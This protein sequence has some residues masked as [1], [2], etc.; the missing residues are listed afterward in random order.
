MR[1]ISPT[2]N[3]FGRQRAGVSAII[4]IQLFVVAMLF[5]FLA[6]NRAQIQRHYVSSQVSSDLAARWGVDLLSRTGDQDL[7]QTQCEELA[8]LNWAVSANS[9]TVQERKDNVGVVV[10]IG[11]AIPTSS[12][13]RFVANQAPFNAVR[14]NN[15]AIV[16]AA[17]FRS[18]EQN[19][20][21][22]ERDATAMAIQRDI[23]VVIDRSGS[24]NFDKTGGNWI[25]D[26]SYHPYNAISN[27]RSRYYRNRYAWFWYW[28]HPTRSRWSDML[29]ALYGLS[30]TLKDTRL[31]EKFSIVS[32]SNSFRGNVY[33]HRGGIS[34]YRNNPSSVEVQPTFD[35]DT[36]V[37]SFDNK[38]KYQMPVAGG[39]NISAGID[40]G[41]RVLTGSNSRAAAF[42]TMIVM[43]DGQYNAG[44]NP[45]I[46]AGDAAAQGIEV[47]TVT[48]GRG[49][50][51][52]TMQQAAAAGNGKHYHAPDGETLAEI[53]SEIANLPPAAFID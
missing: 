2:Q 19:E 50:N 18:T 1:T 45:A 7:V 22:I 21:Y 38:Y 43:T 36:A 25:S 12:G 5:V 40:E 31:E 28:P 20:L 48:F 52:T 35:Y 9:G 44:R 10:E 27:R 30:T 32:Y 26:W 33:D 23:C 14:V 41:I 24:M 8:Q 11:S 47:F 17:G 4:V 16:G 37:A 39:T 15:N 6:V 29:P 46:A 13:M 42:K 53:F 3:K 49:A 51:Q 34:Y